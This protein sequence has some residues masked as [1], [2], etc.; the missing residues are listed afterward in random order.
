[1]FE[2]RQGPRA[3]KDATRR[4]VFSILVALASGVLASCGEGGGGG[5]TS[6]PPPLNPVPSITSLSPSSATAGAAAQTLTINLYS[7]SDPVATT[8]ALA[9]KE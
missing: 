8:N 2:E 4:L 1:M 9:R 5:G 7:Y 3:G 6:P